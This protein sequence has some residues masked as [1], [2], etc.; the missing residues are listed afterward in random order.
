MRGSRDLHPKFRFWRHYTRISAVWLSHIF[1]RLCKC[2]KVLKTA[3]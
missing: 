3:I 2:W 1:S